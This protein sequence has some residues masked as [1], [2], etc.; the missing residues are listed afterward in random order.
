MVL[1]GAQVPPPHPPPL[2]S[3]SQNQF[4]IVPF[5]TP[6]KMPNLTLLSSLSSLFDKSVAALVNLFLHW[7]WISNLNIPYH[8]GPAVSAA[9]PECTLVLLQVV[10]GLRNLRLI[11]AE[12]LLFSAH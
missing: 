12:D 10:G 6:P 8:A 4:E 7:P 3:P 2:F 9:V 1:L 5:R 11:L